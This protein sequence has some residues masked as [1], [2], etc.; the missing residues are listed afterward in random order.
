[1]NWEDRPLLRAEERRN[2]VQEAGCLLESYDDAL[3][4]GPLTQDA[5]ESWDFQLERLWPAIRAVARRLIGGGEVDHDFVRSKILALCGGE[6]PFENGDLVEQRQAPG[7]H[8]ILGHARTVGT[9]GI[10][11]FFVLQNQ[12]TDERVFTALDPERWQVVGRS[13][14]VELPGTE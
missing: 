7:R 8:E 3:E 12:D 14:G 10:S 2:L 6:P 9:S 4:V 5:M 11:A 13:Q 1:M